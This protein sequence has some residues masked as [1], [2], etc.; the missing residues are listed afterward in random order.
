MDKENKRQQLRKEKIEQG[1]E[2]EK[3]EYNSFPEVMKGLIGG[4][5]LLV[6]A[7]IVCT[8]FLGLKIFP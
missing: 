5:L 7:V 4:I 3:R 8:L 2:Q 6:V 1:I